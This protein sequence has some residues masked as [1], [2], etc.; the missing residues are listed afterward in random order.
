MK[1]SVLYFHE[2]FYE[3]RYLFVSL[4]HA[5]RVSEGQNCTGLSCLCTIVFMSLNSERTYA[6]YVSILPWKYVHCQTRTIREKTV[7]V[8]CGVNT[9]G[10][11]CAIHG[12]RNTFPMP[13]TLPLNKPG[14]VGMLTQILNHNFQIIPRKQY[15]KGMS[16]G[17]ICKVLKYDKTWLRGRIFRIYWRA[18]FCRL[19]ILIWM[20]S[21][22]MTTINLFY[23]AINASSG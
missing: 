9:P 7:V 15:L 17:M 8:W 21:C 23:T 11:Y 14:H 2:I 20:A 18:D 4:N 13:Q 12:V 1:K 16:I 5:T 22:G 3:I 6:G 19:E 10:V